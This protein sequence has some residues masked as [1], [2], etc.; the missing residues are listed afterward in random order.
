M[1][2]ICFLTIQNPNFETKWRTHFSVIEKLVQIKT[3]LPTANPNPSD[4]LKISL[5]M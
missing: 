2:L 5:Q 4:K 1:H 3:N